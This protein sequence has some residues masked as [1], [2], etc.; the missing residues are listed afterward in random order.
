MTTRRAPTLADVAA[1]AGVSLATASRAL[2]GSDRVVRAEL[3][4]RVGAAAQRL[5]Y[6]PNAQAQAVVRGSNDAIGLLVN[7]IADPYFSAIAAGLAQAAE[8][9]NLLVMLCNTGGRPE[10]ELEFLTQLRRQRGRAIVLA[11]SRTADRRH[12]AA[13]SAALTSYL[14]AGGRVAAISQARL[15]VDTIVIDNRS[16]ARELA[17]ELVVRGYRSAAVLD[18][19]DSHLTARDRRLGFQEG[20]RAAGLDEPIRYRAEFTR[21]GGYSA[22]AALLDSG[23]PPECV[24]A[25]NDIM[26][27]GA[28]TACREHGLRVPGD[29]AL[30]GFDDIGTLRDVVPALTTV[31]LPLEDIGAAAVALALDGE[32]SATPRRRRIRGEVVLRESTPV[33][34]GLIRRTDT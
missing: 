11:G 4:D 15:P 3:A 23:P 14:Q 31:R 28:L 24:F 32:N 27:M 19:P 25:V 29:V 12:Q 6:M 2:N 7:D 17:A 13:V 33:P 20:W 26:A 5:G 22:M 10:R 18:G 30:A 16:G 21:D 34:R 8:E 1:A 9:Q